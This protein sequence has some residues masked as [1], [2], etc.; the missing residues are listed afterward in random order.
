MAEW[1]ARLADF[2]RPVPDLW[3]TGDHFVGKPTA[4]GL[5][6]RPFI[7][8]Q[9]SSN[10]WITG[11]KTIN[12]QTNVRSQWQMLKMFFLGLWDH[13]FTICPLIIYIFS[14]LLKVFLV[15]Y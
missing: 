13:Q 8:Q 15:L 3:F 1:L 11:A 10:T 9:I 2:S 14:Q 6:T 12:W 5:P 7:H 4:M